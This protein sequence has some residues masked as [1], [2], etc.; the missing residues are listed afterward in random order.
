MTSKSDSIDDQAYKFILNMFTIDH[1][2]E[3]NR[4][5]TVIEDRRFTSFDPVYY[6]CTGNGTVKLVLLRRNS[7]KEAIAA[8]VKLERIL[9]LTFS[10][11]KVL[12]N[13]NKGFYDVNI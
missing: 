1:I 9:G 3:Q 5:V 10:S 6:V 8:V 11:T 7:K 2:R 4:T 12:I 13:T